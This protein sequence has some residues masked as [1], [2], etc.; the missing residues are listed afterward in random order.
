MMVPQMQGDLLRAVLMAAPDTR[1]VFDPFVGSGTA[2]TEAMMLGLDF[3]GCDINPLAVLLCRA[4]VIPFFDSALRDKLTEL[5]ERARADRSCVIEAKFPNWQKWF[6]RDVAIALSRIQRS[7]RLE[8][9]LWARRFFWIAL[10]ETV[11]VSSN[12][13]TSTFKLHIRPLEEQLDRD[14]APIDM[15]AELAERNLRNLESAKARMSERG[16]LH[17]SR[18]RGTVNIHLASATQQNDHIDP[19]ADLLI[20]SPPYGDNTTT[21]PYGQHSFLPL[22]WTTLDDVG[23]DVDHD[24]LKTTHEID[25]RS[26]GGSRRLK[27][28]DQSD[29]CARSKSFAGALRKLKPEPRDRA[30]RVTAFCRDLDRTLDPTLG[31]L[32]KGAYMIWIVGNRKVGGLSLPLDSI[33]TECLESRNAIS[34]GRISRAIPSKRMAV[35]N[36]IAD[37]MG[38]ET[39][40]VLRKG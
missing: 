13:R 32:K 3:S 17:H 28:K 25:Y 23:D 12:S 38:R 9:A 29:L 26:L 2:L 1:H 10:A 15:F 18:Y 5:V 22:Q 33:L 24:C 35:R 27:A 21:I 6:R 36:D 4:K 40:L 14:I 16:H 34:V 7:I 11:R 39:I 8:H 19:K 37:T 30:L 31:K 20:T